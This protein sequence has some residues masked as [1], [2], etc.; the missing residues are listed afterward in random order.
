[1]MFVLYQEIEM[2][3]FR[4]TPPLSLHNS[5]ID[6]STIKSSQYS[7]IHSILLITYLDFFSTVAYLA[8]FLSLSF[9][10]ICDQIN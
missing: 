1:M 4:Q 6:R 8:L 5:L 3:I 10:F 9:L 7:F 2:N